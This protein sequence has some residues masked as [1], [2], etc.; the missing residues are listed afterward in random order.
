[1][2]PIRAA[3]LL[4]FVTAVSLA[5]SPVVVAAVE[6]NA[7][8]RATATTDQVT[9]ESVVKTWAV[10]IDTPVDCAKVYVDVTL[11]ERLAGGK[12]ITTTQRGWRKVTAH[13]TYTATHRIAK[14]SDLTG[15]EFA[16]ARCVVC[17]TE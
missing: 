16:V 7:E 12:E 10:E 11:T 17:G 3:R 15:W 6:C 14:D 8:V 2:R 4:I 5:F 1:M 9:D 13:S